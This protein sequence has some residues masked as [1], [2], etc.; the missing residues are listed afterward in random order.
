MKNKM[1]LLFLIFPFSTVLAQ[2]YQWTWMRGDVTP[3]K[4]GVYGIRGNTSAANKPG[5]RTSAATC[6]D[7]SGNLWL[8]GGYVH[9]NLGNLQLNDLWKYVPS[10]NQWTWISGDSINQPSV[11]GRKDVAATSNQ[12]G[13]REGALTWADASGNLWLFGGRSYMRSTFTSWILNDLWKYMPSTGLWTWIS[14][15]SVGNQAGVYGTK[16]I[17]SSVTVP[18]VRT[19]S[20]GWTDAS[21][22]LWLFSGNGVYGNTLANE[23]NDLWKYTV[24]TGLWTWVGGDSTS[25]QRGVYGTK[26]TPAPFNM[27]GARRGAVHWTDASGNIWLF[28]GEG[29]ATASTGGYPIRSLNDLWK[30]SPATGWWTWVSGDSLLDQ[31]GNY[32]RLGIEA[33]T[34]KPGARNFAI[35]AID[36]SGNL[37]LFGGYGFVTVPDPY[38]TVYTSGNLNDLWK[39]SPSTGLWTWIKGSS[40]T[41]DKGRYGAIGTTADYYTPGSRQ[42]AVGWSGPSHSLW[43]FGGFGP[44]I[45]AS[46]Y[47][48][49]LWKYSISVASPLP[50]QF[51]RFIAQKQQQT[52]ILEWTTAQEQ[53]SRYFVVER[54]SGGTVYDSIGKVAAKGTI[55]ISTNYSFNDTEPLQGTNYYR[56]KQLDLDGMFVYSA[57]AR[58]VM[59][60]DAA[61]FTVVSNPVQNTLQLN[62]QLPSNQKFVMQVRDVNG[63]MLLSKVDMGRTGSSVYSLSIGHL[64]TGT[65]YIQVQSESISGT[66]SFIIK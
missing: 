22:N 62:L 37:L 45:T 6:T 39:Y 55:S 41:D 24:A 32:G 49:D 5:A 18:A 58:V 15:D 16:G 35:G 42:G 23:Y 57:I 53:N 43:L 21:G 28:G 34:N 29:F 27:P 51:S 30:Y 2:Q 52:V 50:V 7:I 65:Y 64:A 61:H 38:M 47:L 33:A 36:S 19:S 9:T 4:T 56:L 13:A 8:F 3:D 12:P 10:T 14:G 25:N 26:G 59:G 20:V 1:F 44:T 46:G 11:Y 40:M 17:P 66:K 54:S 48:S 60:K 63:R 31:T